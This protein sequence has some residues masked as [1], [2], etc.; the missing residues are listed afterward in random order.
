MY[1]KGIPP[2]VRNAKCSPSLVFGYM[3]GNSAANDNVRRD[4]HSSLRGTVLARTKFDKSAQ[5]PRELQLDASQRGRTLE[6][7]HDSLVLH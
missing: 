4:A 7:W 2:P 6:C 3:A 5:Y 1:E